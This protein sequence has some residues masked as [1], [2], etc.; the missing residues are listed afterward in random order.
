MHPLR[1]HDLGRHDLVYH[2]VRDLELLRPT[3][4]LDDNFHQLMEH[5]NRYVVD[6][7]MAHLM[8]LQGVV[9]MDALQ[10]LDVL[11]LDEVLPFQDVVLHYLVDVQVGAEPHHL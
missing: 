6:I 7:A 3:V 1:R 10:N 8:H 11:I 9:M 5:Q 4:R 2:L